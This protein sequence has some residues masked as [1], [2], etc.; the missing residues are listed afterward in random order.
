MMTEPEAKRARPSAFEESVS[1][2]VCKICALMVA[3][4]S[5]VF[6]ATNSALCVITPAAIFVTLL[7]GSSS[8]EGYKNGQGDTSHFKNP[9]WIVVANNGRLLVA[10]TQ[11]HSLRH[12]TP[13]GIVSTV[14]GGG[15]GFADGV[16]TATHFSW[17]WGITVN[18]HSDKKEDGFA[19]G[20]A[21]EAHFLGPIGM[22]MDMDHNLSVL[23]S[24][25]HCICKV[26]LSN[27]RMSTV[28]GS[29]VGGTAGK[30]LE[31]SAVATTR[32][33]QLSVVAVDG[34]NTILD[35]DHSNQCLQ[36][37]TNEGLYWGVFACGRAVFKNHHSIFIN[38]PPLQKQF[39][40]C[41]NFWALGLPLP[42]GWFKHPKT[43]GV[44]RVRN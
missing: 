3:I 11:N 10:D 40:H 24:S 29:C 41:T 17:P 31:E 21:E 35:T 22:A 12:V 16:G 8:E 44:A 7:A 28:A 14:P 20:L 34:N 18:R 19:D 1:T 9:S 6:V 36:R 37:I 25:N 26:A 42:S 27:R 30:G 38:C 13:H 23:D 39:M 15:K 2:L 43:E 5:T 4:N 33:N 32:F